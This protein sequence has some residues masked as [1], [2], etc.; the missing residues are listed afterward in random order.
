MNLQ[1]WV[2][3]SYLVRHLGG[4]LRKED[5]E[6][7]PVFPGWQVQRTFATVSNLAR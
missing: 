2:C 4:L 6:P 3:L 1:T 7:A 5:R